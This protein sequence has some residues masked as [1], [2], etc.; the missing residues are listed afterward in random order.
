MK[1][2]WMSLF[3]TVTLIIV[4]SVE[5][6][7][8]TEWQIIWDEDSAIVETVITDNKELSNILTS[9][10]FK[11]GE[12]EGYF[13]RRSENWQTFNDLEKKFPI[14]AI[15]RN[16]IVFSHTTISIDKNLETNLLKDLDE[17]IKFQFTAF[18]LNIKNTGQ[19]VSELT[20]EWELK[21]GWTEN[22]AKPY[23]TKCILFDGFMLGVFIILVGLICIAIAFL[24]TINRVN[25]LIEE[26]YSLENYL[27][28]QEKINQ[29]EN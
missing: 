28:K 3:L 22:F 21:P 2:M 6:E 1:K 19:K 4:L 5:A 15:T 18:G 13:S 23:L 17:P 25:N 12:E 24:K 29:D 26:E 27:A 14:T 9:S 8:T 10:G 7:A 16:F 11:Q 20:S